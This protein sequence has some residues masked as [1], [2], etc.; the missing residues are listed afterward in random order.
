MDICSAMSSCSTGGCE[1]DVPR[2]ASSGVAMSRTA[3]LCTAAATPE[4]RPQPPQPS[5]QPSPESSPPQ[6]S[7]PLPQ[8]Q[9]PSD[10]RRESADVVVS[11]MINSI[12]RNL[13]SEQTSSAMQT[14]LQAHDLA[15]E[16]EGLQ[17]DSSQPAAP[18]R[19]AGGG[20]FPT[21]ARAGAAPI[22]G[23]SAAVRKGSGSTRKAFSTVRAGGAGVTG[24]SSACA[25]RHRRGR[26]D[27]PRCEVLAERV[28]RT[29]PPRP[30]PVP[31]PDACPTPELP[32]LRR[33]TEPPPPPPP[34]APFAPIRDGG[35]QAC[36]VG[37]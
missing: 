14:H 5:P 23:P 17:V 7:P 32:E 18:T 37:A 25:G 30:S 12:F 26:F 31:T 2:T 19:G 6:P 36:S 10:K 11:A 13:L 20:P 4:R 9:A 29:R 24:A 22:G 16:L 8:P 33:M 35:D 15:L 1:D 34:T 21:R 3:A 27:A 28:L